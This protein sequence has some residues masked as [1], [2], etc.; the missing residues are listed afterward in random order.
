MLCWLIKDTNWIMKKYMVVGRFKEG[1][2]E[3]KYKKFHSEGRHLINGL[4]YLNS[5]VN[6]EEN[7]CFQLMET[8]IR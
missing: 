2:M 7:I 5:C 8:N 6:S 1:R 3:D 4:Y